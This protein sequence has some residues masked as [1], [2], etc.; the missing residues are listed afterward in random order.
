VLRPLF[1]NRIFGCDICQEVCPWNQRLV[2][3]S[4]LLS[5]LSAQSER[6][7]P[8]LLEGFADA[9]PYWLEP[10]AFRQR[11]RRSPILRAKRSGMLRNVCV[12]LGNWADPST[13][14]PLKQ[15][16]YDLERLPRGHAAW[17]LGQVL[18][19][20]GDP[21]A[22][23]FLIQASAQEM[24]PWVREEI[25]EALRGSNSGTGCKGDKAKG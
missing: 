14:E 22:Y 25:D 20:H 3:R 16:L 9:N 17:A 15:A 11:F 8:S 6:I 12:A 18:R 7:A 21:R 13:V 4:P 19:R 5:E 23:D 10:S 2:E 24:D 1:G